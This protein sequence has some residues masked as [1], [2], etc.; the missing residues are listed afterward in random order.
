MNDANFLSLNG[1]GARGVLKLDQLDYLH[2]KMGGKFFRH[3]DVIAGT[4]TGSLITALIA[5]GKTPKEI[6]EIYVR[7]LPNIFKG[8]CLREVIGKSK[9]SND[10]LKELAWS[11]IGNV[12][13][14][15]LTQQ[16]II[17]TVNSSKQETKIFKSFDEKDKRYNLVDVIIASSSA[18]RYFPAHEMNIEEKGKYVQQ[19]FKDGGLSSNNPSD[20]LALE[21]LALDKDENRIYN[22]VNILS[23]TTGENKDAVTKAEKKGNLLSITEM[24]DEILNLQ[25][26]KTHGTVHTLYKYKAIQ[27]MYVRCESEIHNSSGQIDDVSKKNMDAMLE[28][29]RLSALKNRGKI[30]EFYFNTRKND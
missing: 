1:G 4:S 2:Q 21:G 14:G 10:Y 22:N 5:T 30:D 12:K 3:F 19:W 23:I 18:P 9:Y 24:I 25:D 13:L 20:I 29:S 28:D 15:D 11:L 26:K 7:E 27:G 16:I 8:G 17:P 6:R